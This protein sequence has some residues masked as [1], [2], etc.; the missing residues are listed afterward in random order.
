MLDDNLNPLFVCVPDA[1]LKVGPIETEGARQ[2]PLHAE[3]RIAHQLE[4]ATARRRLHDVWGCLEFAFEDLLTNGGGLFDR[5]VVHRSNGLLEMAQFLVLLEKN[6][7]GNGRPDQTV[8][9]NVIGV[10][11]A[12]VE[13]SDS[14]IP[15]KQ[16]ETNRSTCRSSMDHRR[17]KTPQ[18][19]KWPTIP[20]ASSVVI[21][22]RPL[23]AVP[24]SL[25]ALRKPVRRM[26]PNENSGKCNPLA[27]SFSNAVR[28]AGP[29][30]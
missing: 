28:N 21:A 23:R 14:D 4:S 12:R 25:E 13:N 18:G 6:D 20:C 29:S 19:L 5:S 11:G 26:G 8:A 3:D 30:T 15:D 7:R 22:L 1:L 9:I 16:K 2:I 17:R 24:E 27:V 10:A